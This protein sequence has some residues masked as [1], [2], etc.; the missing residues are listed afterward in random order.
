MGNDEKLRGL[1]KGRASRFAG[2]AGIAGSMAGNAV[3]AV[4][5]FA[6]TGSVH[7]ASEEM[8]RRT[9]EKLAASLGDMKGLPMKMGQMLSYVDEFIPAKHR[10]LYRETLNKLQAKT[11][12]MDWEFIEDTLNENIGKPI[13]DAFAEFDIEPIAA[14]SIGQVYEARL[15]DGMKVAVKVQYPGIAEAIDN[16][17]NNLGAMFKPLLMVIPKVAM[18]AAAADLQERLISECDYPREAEMQKL[19]HRL[20]ED[21]EQ[22]IIPRV[23]DELCGPQVLVTEFIEGMTYQDLLEQSTAEECSKAGAILCRFAYQSLYQ[24]GILNT[25]PHPGNYIFL[26]DGRVA[27]LDFGSVQH[28]PESM[29]QAFSN[30]CQAT[31]DNVRGPVVRELIDATFGIPDHIELDEELWK[32][33]E[34]F[35]HLCGEPFSAPQPYTYQPD[36]VSRISAKTGEIRNMLIQRTL[37]MGMW[38]PTQKGIVF[39]YRINFGLN[40]ILAELGACGDWQVQARKWCN[41]QRPEIIDTFLESI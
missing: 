14:A 18:S 11:R 1:K 34:D 28:Y 6:T 16:D 8:H 23:I 24:F 21:D 17:L 29:R 10:T 30:L 13:A 2:F 40:S 15:H 26:K 37:K 12:P 20:Y 39:M 36:L 38:T 3:R 7:K 31:M 5:A 35:I 25:D 19:F 4:G 9:A 22:I 41:E 27:F 33:A 32:V